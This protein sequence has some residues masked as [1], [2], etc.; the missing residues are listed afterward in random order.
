VYQGKCI[1]V[2]PIEPTGFYELCFD[3]EGEAINKFDDRTVNELR[4]A[5]EALRSTPGLKGVL[6]TSAKDVFIVGADI[7]EFGR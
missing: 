3:R 1:R 6:A 7:T 4:Q 5:T 2:T